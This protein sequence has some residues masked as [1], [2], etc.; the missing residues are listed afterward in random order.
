MKNILQTVSRFVITS[1]FLLSLHSS[2]L[3]NQ[4]K[5]DSFWLHK[6]FRVPSSSSSSCSTIIKNIFKRQGQGF[7][8]LRQQLWKKINKLDPSEK[9][10]LYNA[11]ESLHFIDYTFA[12]EELNKIRIKS[13]TLSQ[14]EFPYRFNQGGY[15]R[16]RKGV[17]LAQA[18]RG[19]QVRGM[20]ELLH[21][22][23][24]NGKYT[25]PKNKRKAF[26]NFLH[27]R[28]WLLEKK[29]D[30]NLKNL[31][32]AH[33]LLMQGSIEGLA[34]E[35]L[36]KFRLISVVG[37]V[38]KKPV[39]E[40]QLD[41]IRNNIYLSFETTEELTQN[42]ETLFLGKIIYPNP[43]DVKGEAL[44]RIKETH[45][46][47]YQSIRQYQETEEGNYKELTRNLVNALTEE[48]LN[49]FVLQKDQIGEINTPKKLEQYIDLV[50][51]LQ[52]DFISIHPFRNGNGRISRE[53]ILNY[54]LIKEDFF[55]SRISN[56]NLDL[57][58][59]LEEWKKIIVKGI[60]ST[61]YLYR[62]ISNRLDLG[63]DINDSPELFLPYLLR[64][65]AI[66]LKKYN[67][68]ITKESSRQAEVDARQFLIFLDY[69][70]KE[71][72]ETIQNLEVEPEKS[73]RII[74]NAYAQFFKENKIDYIHQKE[75]LQ[76]VNLH[77]VDRDFAQLF[78]EKT[79]RNKKIWQAKM[80]QW[81]LNQTIWRG[82]SYRSS[83]VSDSEIIGMFTEFHRQMTSNNIVK[84]INRNT[85]P[86]DIRELIF[87]DFADYN[88]DLYGQGLV[89]IAKDHAE[90]GPKY[91]TSY[92]YSTSK[93]RKVGKAFAMGAMVIAPYG[94]QNDPELQKQL[95]SR[96]LVGVKR[97]KKDVD[98]GRL[99]QVRAAFSYKYGRQQEVMGIGAA[100]PDSVM[101]VQKI[102]ADG[103]VIESFVRNKHD[104]SKIHVYAS[105]VND[106]D[107]TNGTNELRIITLE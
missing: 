40:K 64:Q 104:P 9:F 8:I 89:E 51:Q 103:E 99:K 4:N 91:A 47:V 34:D 87:S 75:G 86:E 13:Q 97:A 78:G 43:K 98:F 20:E 18:I 59:S 80:D 32:Q 60:E 105:E 41:T 42:D 71:N 82:L 11:L 56:P 106:I 28:H 3:L 54:A 65:S 72:P 39:T 102:N 33:Q 37:N 48:R 7:L 38:L 15:S 45:T 6:S 93:D 21:A 107:S 16:V 36:G 53:F 76:E 23:K 44:E 101:V 55:P 81:Y 70:A 35:H 66:D 90:T 96:I 12:A 50:I 88:D 29:P 68:K 30:F 24:N 61:D 74:E 49:W 52:R 85:S 67:S 83:E 69:F 73:L 31:K 79:Y 100:E 58:A 22:L 26:E 92:G 62:D 46:E 10:S 1:G 5:I 2:Y 25:P 57:Y 17:G 84:K 14:A 19:K 63:L 94:K 77:F 27:T 95:A